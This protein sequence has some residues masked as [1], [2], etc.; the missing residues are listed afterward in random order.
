MRSNGHREQNATEGKFDGDLYHENNVE[1]SRYGRVLNK[2]DYLTMIDT[3]TKKDVIQ[4]ILKDTHETLNHGQF[5]QKNV[6]FISY[7]TFD[8]ADKRDLYNN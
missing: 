5:F 6:L 4:K 2:P 1:T 8:E 7:W 3:T